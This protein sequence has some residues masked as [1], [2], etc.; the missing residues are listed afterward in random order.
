V[1]AI[2]IVRLA[3]IALISCLNS[4]IADEKSATLDTTVYIKIAEKNVYIP[5]QA[6]IGKRFAEVTKSDTDAKKMAL[7]QRILQDHSKEIDTASHGGN[8]GGK[9]IQ[10]YID[11]PY[12]TKSG[13]MVHD[14][15]AASDCPPRCAV[16]TLVTPASRALGQDCVVIFCCCNLTD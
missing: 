2:G 1:K 16:N 4:A 9:V 15:V 5:V 3:A 11:I 12:N 10:L 8:I 14:F 7:V 13:D 6:R